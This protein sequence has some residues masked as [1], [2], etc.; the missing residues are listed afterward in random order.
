[1]S[2]FPCE[3]EV[4]IISQQVNWGILLLDRVVMASVKYQLIG[5]KILGDRSL[6]MSLEAF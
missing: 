1:M 5:L 6:E 3:F 2:I 4:Y